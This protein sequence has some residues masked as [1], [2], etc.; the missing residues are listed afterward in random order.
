VGAAVV[1]AGGCWAAS[2]QA[3]TK[4]AM[5][6]ANSRLRRIDEHRFI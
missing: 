1:G 4:L 5:V 6:P 2:G 3:T